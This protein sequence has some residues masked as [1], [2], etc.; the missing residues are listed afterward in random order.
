[1]PLAAERETKKNRKDFAGFST[2]DFAVDSVHK[3]A[4][5]VADDMLSF[6]TGNKPGGTPGILPQGYFCA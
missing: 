6:Y 4:K 5:G 2:D 3:V 1:M